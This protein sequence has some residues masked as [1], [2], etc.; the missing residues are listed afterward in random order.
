[1]KIKDLQDDLKKISNSKETPYLPID[2][3]KKSFDKGWF[4][5]I[6]RVLNSLEKT[7]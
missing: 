3:D 5:A 6:N 1:M 2:G 7:E 4:L